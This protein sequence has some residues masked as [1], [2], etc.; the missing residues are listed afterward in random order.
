MVAAAFLGGGE[1]DRRL[2]DVAAWQTVLK[3]AGGD[4]EQRKLTEA[5]TKWKTEKPA[6]DHHTVIEI[7]DNEEHSAEFDVKIPAGHTLEIR[8]TNRFR[9]LL[10]VPDTSG[11]EVEKCHITGLAGSRL[12]LDGLLFGEGE[13]QLDGEFSSILIRHCTFTPGK[14]HLVIK[15]NDTDI[16]IEH[17]IVGTIVTR[18]RCERVESEAEEKGGPRD[19]Y[20]SANIQRTGAI[21]VLRQPSRWATNRRGP[22]A[23]RSL[24]FHGPRRDPIRS[25]S[26]GSCGPHGR[27][28]NGVRRSRCSW[29]K[30]HREQH[31]PRLRPHSELPDRLRA[32]SATWHPNRAPHPNSI[33]SRRWP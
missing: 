22:A 32:L 8:A 18:A 4:K 29:H 33:A 16:R 11:Q 3:A 1:Y 27:P 9:P 31:F 14:T 10:R 7:G 30:A 17:S 12:I 5:I 28:H 19:C 6:Q 13:I 2:N 24:R 20:L 15:L 21:V 25:G 26:L 23:K